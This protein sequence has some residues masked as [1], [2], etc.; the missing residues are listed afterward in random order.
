MRVCIVTSYDLSR[1]G[2]V[3]RHVLGLRDALVALGDSV[4]V[5]GPSSGPLP[6]GCHGLPGVVGVPANGSMAHIG[7]LGRPA[8]TV[9]F[10]RQ[11]RFNLVHVHEPIVPGPARHSVAW[12]G[13]PVVATFHSFAH[14]ESFLLRNAR[15]LVCSPLRKL[16]HGIAVSEAARRFATV[17]YGGPIAV[18]PNGIVGTDFTAR[19]ERAPTQDRPLRVLFAG[20][21]GERRKGLRYLLLAA[22]ELKRRGHAL[23]VVVVGD[24][25]R[26]AFAALASQANVRFVGRVDDASLAEHYR[27]ADLFC[28]PSIDGESFGLVLI[29]AMA[30]GCPVVASDIPGYAEAAAGCAV[31]VPPANPNALATALWHVG[32]DSALQTSLRQ[33][34]QRRAA[35]LDWRE[36]TPQVRAIY[37]LAADL[38]P[39]AV[40]LAGVGT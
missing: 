19:P 21:F 38:K 5:L 17:I 30:A 16:R 13:V 36:L 28:A 24:G 12:S 40:A 8:D 11:G 33:R 1:D 9:D 39:E 35:S 37:A 34:G 2:G 22:T 26:E 3:N 4:E 23:D 6:K 20:R 10:L 14:A 25:P 31:L 15:R 29:E 27:Q 32:Q 18:I 7:L